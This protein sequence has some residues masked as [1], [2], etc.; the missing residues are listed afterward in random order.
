MS[1]PP[2]ARP[3]ESQ[4]SPAARGR[5]AS[6]SVWVVAGGK[7]GVGRSLL[8][9]NMGIQMARL[10]KRVVACDLDFQSASL[11]AYLGIG[12][13][14]RTLES[15]SEAPEGAGV[16]PL[17]LDTSVS[18]LK[19]VAG[20][21]VGLPAERRRKV[22]ER[23]F[24]QLQGLAADLVLIDCGSGRSEEVLDLLR[25]AQGGILVATPEPACLASIYLFM[26]SLIDSELERS[27]SKDD[28][29]KLEIA[30]SLDD[31][32]PG[33]RTSL[34]SALERLRGE[35]ESRL[36]DAVLAALRP[37]RFRL[38]VNQV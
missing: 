2:E 37:Y 33:A 3:P 22:V 34:R 27:L 23:L 18:G 16:A 24:A 1:R 9:A 15:L 29:E 25:R 35:G 17:L 21:Q 28:R 31:E 5:G 13:P 32:E 38:V 26:E 8:V 30:R 19:L 10:G 14:A 7:G 12:R 11:H 4:A 20:C 36:V 6:P